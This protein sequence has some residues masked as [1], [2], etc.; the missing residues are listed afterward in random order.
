MANPNIGAFTSMTGVTAVQL[1]TNSAT[2]IVSNAAASG[3]LYK[4]YSLSIANTTTSN[5]TITADL[6]RSSTAY[7][8]AGSI[9]VP[10][11]STLVLITKDNGVYLN[12]ND[13]LRL[14]GGASSGL[15][16][17]CS[18]EVIS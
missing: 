6:Y 17:V 15:E 4:I 7:R 11:N 12:E 1:V 9:S 18:Y 13:A 10:A 3:A 5:I 2:A 16:A 8:I 14:T